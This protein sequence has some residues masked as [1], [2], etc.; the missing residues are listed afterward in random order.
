MS[1]EQPQS[2]T[3][4]CAVPLTALGIVLVLFL[5]AFPI[6]RAIIGDPM[7]K[8]ES[9]AGEVAVKYVRDSDGADTPFGKAMGEAIGDYKKGRI[10]KL[11]TDKGKPPKIY[12]TLSLDGTKGT[13]VATIELG[14]QENQYEVTDALVVRK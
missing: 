7:R 2:Q 12:V 10:I 4:S 13:G 5:I 11:G 9:I 1:D 3:T 8:I 6:S 14:S